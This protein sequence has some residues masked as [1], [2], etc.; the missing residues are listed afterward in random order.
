MPKGIAGVVPWMRT[1]TMIVSDRKLGRM[2]DL[3]FDYNDLRGQLLRS[4]GTDR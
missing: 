4:P 1:P 2:V 3:S